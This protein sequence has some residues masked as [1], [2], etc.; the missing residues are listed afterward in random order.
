MNNSYEQLSSKLLTI[1]LCALLA[2]TPMLGV[3]LYGLS[4]VALDVLITLAAGVAVCIVLI[5]LSYRYVGGRPAGKYLITTL[6]YGA[7]LFV[8]FGVPSKSAWLLVFLYFVFS[9]IYLNTRVTVLSS[10]YG[11]GILATHLLSGAMEPTVLFDRLVVG[12]VYV[13]SCI[14]GVAICYFGRR[15][16]A[17][18]FAARQQAQE[19]EERLAAQVHVMKGTSEEVAA[20]S[21]E[22]LASIE[23]Q[24]RG[25]D[26]VNRGL[27]ETTGLVAAMVDESHNSGEHMRVLAVSSEEIMRQMRTASGYVQRVNEASA[28]LDER[29]GHIIG[30]LDETGEL[31][32]VTETV[33][34]ELNSKAAAINGVVE[35]IRGVAANTKL[36]AL[37]ASIEAARAGEHGRGFAVV[38][39]EVGQLAEQTQDSLVQIEQEVQALI[40]LISRSNDQIALG[41][42]TVAQNRADLAALETAAREMEAY[43][44][45]TSSIVDQVYAVS[46]ESELNSRDSLHLLERLVADAER[47]RAFLDKLGPL[48]QSTT[49]VSHEIQGLAVSLAGSAER[50]QLTDSRD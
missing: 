1:T 28:L 23:T 27:R 30:S 36:L 15:I 46:Q 9:L 18:A 34:S 16:L 21:E 43:L 20:G 37:N 49:N 42:R 38:A 29:L 31:L 44:H 7:C 48:M 4:L 2:A 17:D 14:A 45:D 50:L 39:Q 19:Q 41:N 22:L 11:L 3:A 13:M 25:V 5:W 35:M 33:S 6:A 32:S 26:E 40:G 8:S 10:L 47:V 24:N 12:I